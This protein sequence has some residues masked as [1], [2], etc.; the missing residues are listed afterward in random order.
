MI[1]L[2]SIV[3]QILAVP[4]RQGR[5]IIALAGAPASGKTTLAAQLRENILNSCVVPMDGFH[6]SNV[7]LE[8]HGLLACKGAPETFDAEGFVRKVKSLRGGHEIDFPTF[9]RHSDSVIQNGGRV[10]AS[11]ETILVEGNYLLLNHQ[12]W[13]A[14]AEVWD[15]SLLIDVPL[16]LLEQRLVQRWV[17]HGFDVPAAQKRAAQNDLP[18]ARLTMRSS[19][20]AH[21]RVKVAGS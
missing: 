19:Y 9:D 18:N 15:F 2:Q 21:A 17:Q 12:P 11:D 13:R 1:D 7:D 14:L 16:D 10:K 20:A 4:L 6:R 8:E 3:D 5:R